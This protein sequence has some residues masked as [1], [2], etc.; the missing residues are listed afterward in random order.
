MIVR[1]DEKQRLTVPVALA[2]AAPGDA[3]DACFDDE[4]DAI[5]FRRK[6]GRAHV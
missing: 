6:I 2:P 1:L 5:I 3:F 4:E